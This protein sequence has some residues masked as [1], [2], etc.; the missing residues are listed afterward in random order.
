M[1]NAGMNGKMFGELEDKARLLSDYAREREENQDF[2]G[3]IQ[4][5][6]HQ[7][8]LFKILVNVHNRPVFLMVEA[9]AKLAESYLIMDYF[10]QAVDHAKCALRL[11]GNLFNSHPESKAYHIVLLTLLAKCLHSTEMTEDSISLLEKA[12]KMSKKLVGEGH[13]D[14][15]PI[16]L[17]L[18]KVYSKCKDF[19]KALDLLTSVWEIYETIHGKR[20]EIML[21]IYF[22]LAEV[23]K[24]KKD[25]KNASDM[26]SRMFNLS[27]D[28]NYNGD[29]STATGLKLVSLLRKQK[30]LQESLEIL[31]KC[32]KLSEN[33]HGNIH[34]TTAKVKRMKCIILTEEEK[35]EEALSECFEVLEID[36]G[37][38]GLNSSHH[39]KDLKIIG[40]IFS[41]LNRF[42][43]ALEYLNN[44]FDLYSKLRNKKAMRELKTKIESLKI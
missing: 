41:M 18:G 33:L 19:E 5:R 28:L 22:N 34:K 40:S 35:Y 3:V 11:N 7:F 36:K 25:S 13:A 44:S 9:H 21:E 15:A 6:A 4:V 37:L 32:E 43:E 27:I 2:E 26:L 38:Y 1:E 20:H 8:A 24:L 31:N 16:M 39:A 29:F 42:S 30:R 17:E 12:L 10:E 23:Y 14:Q